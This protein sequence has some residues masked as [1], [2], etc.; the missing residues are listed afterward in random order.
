M[1][2]KAVAFY[3]KRIVA[4]YGEMIQEKINEGYDPYLLTIM[5][6]EIRGPRY[7]VIS[8]ILENTGEAYRRCLKR[9]VR[10]PRRLLRP[11]TS[12]FGLCLRISL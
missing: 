6:R 8:R 1:M 10:N 11:I 3:T 12:R 4:A 2:K 5:S 9:V 7:G